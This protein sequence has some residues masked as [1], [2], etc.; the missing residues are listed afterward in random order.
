MGQRAEDLHLAQALWQLQGTAA[1]ARGGERPLKKL[2]AEGDLAVGADEESRP[3]KTVNVPQVAWRMPGCRRRDCV[4]F[5]MAVSHLVSEPQ[6]RGRN[7][8]PEFI[9]RAPSSWSLTQR[10]A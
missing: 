5:S 4:L 3:Q 7:S 1:V 9:A 10:S 8:G 6:L 2:I